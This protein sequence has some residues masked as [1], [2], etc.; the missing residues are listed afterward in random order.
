MLLPPKLDTYLHEDADGTGH[1]DCTHANHAN[2]ICGMTLLF[3]DIVDELIL[4]RHGAQLEE[5]Q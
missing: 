2:L 4:E 3:V 1:P 5:K